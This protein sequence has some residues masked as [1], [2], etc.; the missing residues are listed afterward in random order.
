[1]RAGRE[2]QTTIDSSE[3]EDEGGEIESLHDG[4]RQQA[5]NAAVDDG[6]TEKFISSCLRPAE[7]CIE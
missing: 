4:G 1:M 2:F 6:K 7:H 5:S 3:E